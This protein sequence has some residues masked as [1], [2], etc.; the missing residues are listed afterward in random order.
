MQ[1]TRTA[2]TRFFGH[3]TTPG[4]SH[5]VAGYP[6]SAHAGGRLSSR[7]NATVRPGT[8][9]Q[10]LSPGARHTL[11]ST[12]R[13]PFLPRA[14]PASKPGIYQV[15]LGTARNFSTARPLF[16]NL[17]QNV[18]IAGRAMY[19]ADWDLEKKLVKEKK[20]RVSKQAKGKE[21]AAMR[22]PSSL[23]TL[24]KKEKKEKNETVEE[25]EKYF[26]EQPVSGAQGV[27]TVLI[28]PLAPTP[29]ARVPLSRAENNEVYRNGGPRLLNPSELE[30][31][32]YAYSVHAL[33]L[34]SLFSR[35]DA[36]KVWERGVKSSA[37]G[38]PR[39]LCT[40][41]RVEFVGWTEVMV[42]DLLG[43]AGRGWCKVVE[44]KEDDCNTCDRVEEDA[45]SSAGLSSSLSSPSSPFSMS[46]S[47]SSDMVD[48]SHSVILPTLDFSNSLLDQH[49]S[50]NS[51]GRTMFSP[52]ISNPVSPVLNASELGYEPSEFNI[53]DH[54]SSDDSLDLDLDSEM[55][56]DVD[57]FSDDAFSEMGSHW[58]G[59]DGWSEVGD[60]HSAGMNTI[61]NTDER[62]L[63]FSTEFA[64]RASSSEN[65][66]RDVMF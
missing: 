18:P 9:H 36:S 62:P 49:Q 27:T 66:P 55:D 50:I 61:T 22:P 8:I 25:L 63:T 40:V 42:K 24:P 32:G 64:E 54:F 47:L 12:S 3:L 5:P 19:E 41:L 44:L 37:H 51:G 1:T 46:R 58:S 45:L 10:G 21:N 23:A 14:S 38:D 29:T 28:I 53:E 34:S 35:L 60:E 4:F 11:G 16:Q 31:N 13:G 26:P 57:A 2:F 30:A 15:G 17:V 6:S 39:G 43:D 52:P 7:V 65:L 48:P 33:R 56:L 20:M 59:S